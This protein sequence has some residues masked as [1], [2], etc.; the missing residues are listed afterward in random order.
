MS[1]PSN[2]LQNKL[3]ALKAAF[4]A[5]LPN[6]IQEIE[7]AAVV[8]LDTVQALAHKLAGSAGTYGFSNLGHTARNLELVCQSL[9]EPDQKSSDDG[10]IRVNE[11]ISMLHQGAKAGFDSLLTQPPPVTQEQ[12]DIISEPSQ[13]GGKNIILVDDDVEQTSMLNQ[14]LSNFGFSVRIL[15]HPSKLR[16]A[17]LEL[18]PAAVIMDII[19]PDDKDAGLTTINTLRNDGIL[20]CPVIFISVREDFKARL[21]AIRCGSDGYIVKPIN[22]IEMVETLER[23]IE[24]NDKPPL[25]V[26]IVDDDPEISD[27]C[28]TVLEGKGLVTSTVIDPL[29]AVDAMQSFKPDVI[30]MDI[31]MPGCNGFELASVIR[32]M[33]DKF[34]QVPILFLTAHSEK[35]NKIRA[36]ETGSEGFIPKPVDPDLMVRLVIAR[37]ERSRILKTLFRRMKS[38]EERFS[39]ITR[40]ANEAIVS[41]NDRGLILSWNESAKRIFGYRSREILGKPVTLLIPE[42]FRQAHLQGYKRICDGGESINIGKTIELY[43]IRKD[44][45]EFPLDMSLSNWESNG[46]MFFAATMRDI[47]NRRESEDLL[48]S[49]STSVE[50]MHGVMSAASLYTESNQALQSILDYICEAMGWPIGHIYFISQDHPDTLAPSNIWHST[51]SSKFSPF[52]DATMTSHFKKGFGLPGRVFESGQPLWIQDVTVDSNFIRAEIAK[53]VGIRT[54]FALPVYIAG[55]IKAVLEF[56]STESI[57]SDASWLATLQQISDQIGRVI[58]RKEAEELLRE[59]EERYRQITDVSSDWV[60]EMDKDLRIS[61]LSPGFKRLT[62]MD[63]ALSMGKTRQESTNDD[64]TADHWQRHLADLAAHREFRNFR[65]GYKRLNGEGMQISISGRPVFDDDGNFDGYRGTATDVTD[66]YHARR[67]VEEARDDAVTANQAKSAFLSSMS[68]ELRT[69]LNAILGFGQ[70]LEYNPKEPLT[71]DQKSSV[72]QIL[73][74]GKHLLELINDVLDLARIEAGKVDLLIEDVRFGKVLD[75]CLSLVKEMAANRKIDFTVLDVIDGEWSVRADMTRTKQVLLNLISNAIK[76]NHNGGTITIATENTDHAMLRVS[77]TDSG[78]G[79]PENRQGEL[80]QPF[81]RLGAENSEIEGTGIGLVVCKDLVELMGGKIG[82]NSEPGK[83]STFF[84]ELP[85]SGEAGNDASD[86]GTDNAARKLQPIEGTM[87]YVEDNPSNLSLMEAIVSHI[88]G[89]TMLSAHNAE[90]GIEIARNKRPDIIILDI[91]LT[92]MDGFQALKALKDIDETKDIPVLALSAAATQSDINK[93]LEAG[94]LHYLTKPI[95]VV[96][97]TKAIKGAI[98]DNA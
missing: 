18:S 29:R 69:P 93:G 36:A 35:A 16:D 71:V 2:D 65:Y 8:S 37:A 27:F 38:G 59:S 31:E 40:T 61:H 51:D 97:M 46:K 26:L 21:D 90:L 17:V 82:F 33:G 89:L 14:L 13:E 62:G 19:F 64:L 76:Y 86:S 12:D 10:I 1:N 5:R 77:V 94:F 20:T 30:L 75:E 60:W 54:G 11:L 98:D 39:S 56:F 58:E 81:S 45:S 6:K 34:L 42:R 78:P 57:E 74:G 50:L 67:A 83:G 88:D 32:Q 92:G 47:T 24:A 22:I 28:M 55:K 7:D 87:L 9:T 95:Q 72:K 41:A 4:A 73:K 44:G 91:N 80:F 96:E 15:D 79:I 66:L 53:Q 23:L 70:M 48:K 85:I 84:F 63:P 52:R 3:A 49:H 43:G 68:H 25:R